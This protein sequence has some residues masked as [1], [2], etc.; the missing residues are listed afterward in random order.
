M[1]SPFTPTRAGSS[2]SS[3]TLSPLRRPQ[4]VPRGGVGVGWDRRGS[5]TVEEEEEDFFATLM[6][7]SL[8]LPLFLCGQNLGPQTPFRPTVFLSPTLSSFHPFSGRECVPTKRTSS[9]NTVYF[10]ENKKSTSSTLTLQRNKQ[11][12]TPNSSH[13][14]EFS[15]YTSVT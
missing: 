9:L 2:S 1:H 13:T 14:L 10:I 7:L 8:P 15:Q 12:L 4:G 6:V 11:F 5:K 3:T